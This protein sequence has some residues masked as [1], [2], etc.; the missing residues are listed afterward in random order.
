MMNETLEY[1]SR[2]AAVG[3]PTPDAAWGLLSHSITGYDWHGGYYA[4]P[5][6]GGRRRVG[7]LRWLRN[8]RAAHEVAQLSARERRD[9]R[10]PEPARRP[11]GRDHFWERVASWAGSRTP[12]NPCPEGC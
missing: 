2:R 4:A 7:L 11:P 12:G 10:L 1:S 8:R 3:R 9:V 5:A 6:T